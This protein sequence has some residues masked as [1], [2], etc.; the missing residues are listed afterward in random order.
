MLG[1]LCDKGYIITREEL[2]FELGD[3]WSEIEL[4]TEYQT[5]NEKILLLKKLQAKPSTTEYIEVNNEYEWIS[6]LQ[7]SITKANS[8]VLYAHNIEPN[9]ILGLVNCLR[10]EPQGNKIKCF[11]SLDGN[12]N[13]DIKAQNTEMAINVFKNNKKGTYRHLLLDCNKEVQTKHCVV[14]NSTMGDL[15]S[16]KWFEGSLTLQSQVPKNHS[17]VFVGVFTTKVTI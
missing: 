8:V 5:E 13:F 14:T 17:L 9:G 3:Q 4:F 11:F 15:S 2:N 16:L 1:A 12:F 6:C 7:N 10:R